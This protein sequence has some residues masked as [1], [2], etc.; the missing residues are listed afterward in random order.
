MKAPL[1][2]LLCIS[3]LGL[4]ACG[5]Y[6]TSSV[7]PVVGDAPS[8]GKVANAPK[9]PAQ[10]LVTEN[11]ITNR[12]YRV[13]G[14]VNV[15]VRKVTIFDSD[16]TR[17]KVNAALQDKAAELGADAVVLVRYGAVGVGVFSWGQMDGQGRAIVFN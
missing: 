6:A 13:L 15:T 2:I 16:P 5:T 10:V 4:S 9:A 1:R 14:D 3:L 7:Q 12:P 17:E 11:D 8:V